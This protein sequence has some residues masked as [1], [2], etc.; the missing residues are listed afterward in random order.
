MALINKV[1]ALQSTLR[2]LAKTP[3]S[4]SIGLFSYKRNRKVYILKEDEHTFFIKENG[5][6]VSEKR[7]TIQSL[8]KEL[9]TI[10]KREFPRSRKIRIYKFADL[11]EDT[12]YH[13][14]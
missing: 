14:I 1:S 8:E 10:I 13:K 12:S 3:V 7:V 11:E 5:F 2:L 4:H 9:R 6:L